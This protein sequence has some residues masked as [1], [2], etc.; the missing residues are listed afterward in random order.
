MTNADHRGNK[1]LG[2]ALDY[3]MQTCPRDAER[4]TARIEFLLAAGDRTRYDLR[5]VLPYPPRPH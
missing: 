1:D 4:L 3:V 5:G 2:T